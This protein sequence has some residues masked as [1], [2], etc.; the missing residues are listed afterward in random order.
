MSRRKAIATLELVL[1]LPVI[2]VLMVALV[3]LG[4]SVVGQA[5]VTTEARHQAWS[6]R[7]EAWTAAPLAFSEQQQAE[8]DATASVEVSPLLDDFGDPRSRQTVEQANWDHRSINFQPL[9]NWT[10]YAEFAVAAKREGLLSQYED[11]RA[12]F[13]QLESLSARELADALLQAAT[14]LV[15]PA[16]LFESD[17]AARQRRLE[18]DRDLDAQDRQGRRQDL[19]AQIDQQEQLIQRLSESDVPDDVD[20]LWLAEQKLERLKISRELLDQT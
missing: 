9:P 16:N 4:F 17:G 1:A 8:A 19:E 3:W 7:F 14:E 10:L 5:T 2:L 13:A 18:L 12:E 6:Q 20:R 11:A 15:N